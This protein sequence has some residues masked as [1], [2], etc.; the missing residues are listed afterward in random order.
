MRT[1]DTF[2][3]IMDGEALYSAVAHYHLWSGNNAQ[4]HSHQELFGQRAV[5]ATFDLPSFIGA[6]AMRLPPEQGLDARSLALDNT[7]VRYLTAF[8]PRA[9]ADAAIDRVIAGDPTLHVGL[10]VNASVVARPEW[11]LFCPECLVAMRERAGRLWWRLDQQLPG[12][13]ICPQH[14]VVLR[15]STIRF[16][17]GQFT[18]EAATDETCPTDA[19]PVIEEPDKRL[20]SQLRELAVRSAALLREEP[21]FESYGE[22][23]DYYRSRLHDADL[24]ITRRQLDVDKFSEAFRIFSC[25][26]LRVL[27]P[28]FGK[29]GTP[30]AWILEMAR[31]HTQAKH[32]LQHL[33]FGM[34]LDQQPRRVPPFG[35]GPWACPNPMANHGAGALTIASVVERREGHGLV[36][37]FECGC[38]YV[39]T[40]SIDHDGALRGPRYRCFGP[41]LDPSLTRLVADGATLRG[42]AAALGIHPRAVAAA[43]QRLGLDRDWKVDQKAGPRLGRA[44]APRPTPRRVKNPKPSRRPSKPRVD[45]QALDVATLAQVKDAIEEIRRESP[46]VLLCMREIERRI[47]RQESWIYLRRSKLPLTAVWIAGVVE[48][49]EQFQERRLRDVIARE[50]EKGSFLT[51]SGVVRAASLKWEV[52]A[53]RARELLADVAAGR[54][55]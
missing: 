20:C 5:R 38:G 34:F 15:R 42:A 25:D 40:M 28:S 6:L 54:L 22:M 46:I 10:G 37:A 27:A 49:V 11:L 8:M 4:S 23:T 17:S 29:V 19:K 30:D 21:R 13:L 48:T 31:K 50:L 18:F 1:I 35:E 33:L 2:P 7:P 24:M 41:L 12:V 43:A 3:E 36:G 45:W 32:P 51:A 55:S 16:S 26:L 9:D 39:Y 53:D 52:W 47:G 44:V 14:G